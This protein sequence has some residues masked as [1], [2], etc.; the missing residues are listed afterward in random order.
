MAGS[1][2]W[3][4]VIALVGTKLEAFVIN[5]VRT[6]CK[7]K[8]MTPVVVTL[9]LEPVGPVLALWMILANGLAV[10]R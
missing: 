5:E 4:Y 6:S 7:E 9:T 2:V 10:R 1:C 8:T 3:M